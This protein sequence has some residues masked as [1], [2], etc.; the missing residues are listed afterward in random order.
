ML[1]ALF[2][3]VSCTEYSDSFHRDEHVVT[4]YVTTN[5]SVL[6]E[7]LVVEALLRRPVTTH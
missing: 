1:C 4:R 5:A 2:V 3:F 7:D 6:L